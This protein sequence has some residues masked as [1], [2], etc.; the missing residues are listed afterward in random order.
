VQWRSHGQYSEG[1]LVSYG[2]LVSREHES[3]SSSSRDR[4]IPRQ[5]KLT[6]CLGKGHSDVV[7]VSFAPARR[8]SLQK[9]ASVMNGSTRTGTPSRVDRASPSKSASSAM[10]LLRLTTSPRP[11][12]PIYRSTLF[13]MC[14]VGPSGRSPSWTSFQMV[15]EAKLLQPAGSLGL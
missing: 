11:C 10:A 7:F 15:R 4:C 8:M 3:S 2:S 9:R 1:Y 6:I 5:F 12:P 13:E 14:F